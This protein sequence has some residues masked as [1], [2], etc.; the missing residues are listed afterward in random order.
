MTDQ[1]NR[2]WNE[3]DEARLDEDLARG[4][5]EVNDVDPTL[6]EADREVRIDATEGDDLPVTPPDM[7]PRASEREMAGLPEGEE[8]IDERIAQEEPDPDSA[9]GAPVD[10]G[11]LDR[12]T[13]VGGDDD[14]AIPADRDFVGAPDA[15]DDLGLYEGE[16][17]VE[18][19]AP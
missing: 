2:E 13:D 5:H 14:D 16:V 17:E 6:A 11:G 18:E 10:E 19:D 15:A 3:T 1:S 7:Q 8:T 12:R 9:Y 4:E